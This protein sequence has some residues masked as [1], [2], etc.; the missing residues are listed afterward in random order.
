MKKNK[1]IEVLQN[2]K[3]NPDIKMWNGLVEDWM[4][5]EISESEL[6]K[7]CKEYIRWGVEMDWKEE[8]KSWEIPDDEKKRLDK[9][10]EQRYKS[11]EWEFPNARLDAEGEKRWYGKNRKKVVL[12]HHKLRNQRTEDRLGE[13][14]Y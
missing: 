9:I 1:L 2:I 12:V 6:V 3:G 14:R 8:N 4:D 13:I 7:C 5:I 10:V 11:N